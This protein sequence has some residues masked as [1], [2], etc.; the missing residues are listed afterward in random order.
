[1]L[2]LH[3]FLASLNRIKQRFESINIC[4]EQ[5]KRLVWLQL[6][7]KCN[8]LPGQFLQIDPNRTEINERDVL[9]PPN[10]RELFP[11]SPFCK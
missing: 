9:Y 1:M 7:L 6:P 8:K 5:V 4:P 10:A 3:N 11:P 2:V